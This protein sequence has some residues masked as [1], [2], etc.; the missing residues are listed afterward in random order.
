[1]CSPSAATRTPSA[2]TRSLGARRKSARMPGAG[3][4]PGSQEVKVRRFIPRCVAPCLR[5][6][7]GPLFSGNPKGGSLKNVGLV[8]LARILRLLLK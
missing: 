2:S 5:A 1:M 8:F 6:T 3:T 4:M 7:H